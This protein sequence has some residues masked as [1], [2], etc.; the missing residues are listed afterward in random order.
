MIIIRLQ[1]SQVWTNDQDRTI[2]DANIFP[3]KIHCLRCAKIMTI[4]HPE[5][6][7]CKNCGLSMKIAEDGQILIAT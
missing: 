5:T 1:W 7:L 2:T 6:V 4:Q 3:L